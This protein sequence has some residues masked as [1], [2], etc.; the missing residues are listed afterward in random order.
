VAGV[1]DLDGTPLAIREDDR[2]SVVRER[3]DAYEQQTRPLLE[4]F[5]RSGRPMIEIDASS[6]TPEAVFE[7]ILEQVQAQ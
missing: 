1:C 7:K 2:E 4:Y 6:L 3:L 5:R